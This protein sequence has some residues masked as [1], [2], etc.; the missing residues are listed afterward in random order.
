MDGL[1]ASVCRDDPR[2]VR[3]RRADAVGALAAGAQSLAGGCESRLPRRPA[4]IGPVVIH[5]VATADTPSGRSETPALLAGYGALPAPTVRESPTARGCARDRPGKPGAETGIDRPRA[6]AEFV[7]CRDLTCRFPCCDRPAEVAD[8]DHARCR[9]R[10]G[11]RIRSNLK[12]LCRHHHL[13]KTH[14]C[15]PGGWHDRQFADGTVEWTSPTGH[16]YFT[17]PG[18]T[19][20]FPQLVTTTQV[21]RRSRRAGTTSGRGLMMPTRQ[22]T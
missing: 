18:G 14:W 6:L 10:M 21:P 4:T 13:L 5:V 7:R 12:L 17:K 3:Q 22:R 15:G 11:P 16:T 8:L 9:I 19:L 2:T 1:A 20:F